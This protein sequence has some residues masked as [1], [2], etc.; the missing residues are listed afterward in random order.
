M[1]V[2]VGSSASATVLEFLPAALETLC[3]TIRWGADGE[4]F[5]PVLEHKASEYST[6]VPRLRRL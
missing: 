6:T 5:P 3:L 2:D 1:V 4:L